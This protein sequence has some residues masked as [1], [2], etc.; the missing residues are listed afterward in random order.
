MLRFFKKERS[1]ENLKELI[2]EFKELKEEIERLSQE[3]EEIKRKNKFTIQKVGIVRFNPFKEMGGNQSFSLALLDEENNGVVIT[4][5]YSKEGNRIYAKPIIQEKS[6]YYLSKE[7][8]EA[9]QKAQKK[10]KTNQKT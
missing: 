9:I 7:E 4:S 6:E 5:L 2:K 1:P 10:W 3:V 8:V